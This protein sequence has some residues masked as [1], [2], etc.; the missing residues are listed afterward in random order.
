MRSAHVCGSGWWQRT[1]AV[2][3]VVA[4]A[5]GVLAPSAQASPTA[6]ATACPE[7][8]PASTFGDVYSGDVH[9]RAVRCLVA[10]GVA[11]GAAL[12]SYAPSSAVTRGQMATFLAR[13][14]RVAGQPLDTPVQGQFDDVSGTHRDNIEALADLGIVSGVDASTF[15]PSR[16]VT[17]AQMATFID[18]VL[19]RFGSDLA[20]GTAQFE[21]VNPSSVHASAIRKLAAADIAQGRSSSRFDPNGA[22]TRAQMA[23]F[24]MRGG[25][26]LAD[27]GVLEPPYRE[28]PL[29]AALPDPLAEVRLDEPF[30]PQN[31]IVAEEP[32]RYVT[33]VGPELDRF[34]HRVYYTVARFAD[35]A[36]AATAAANV[37]DWYRSVLPS[38]LVTEY[39]TP[40]RTSLG[41]GDA[42]EWF[43]FVVG[44]AG[45]VVV[46]ASFGVAGETEEA[47]EGSDAWP[48]EDDLAYAVDY[49][50]A[51]LAPDDPVRASSLETICGRVT[52][53]PWYVVRTDAGVSCDEAMRVA[54]RYW[55]TPPTERA[56]WTGDGFFCGLAA[57]RALGGC[58]RLDDRDV[59][60]RMRA[61]RE[62]R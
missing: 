10:Y 5:S 1:K 61:Q 17:R 19:T 51:W 28:D 25:D 16:A 29:R 15:E 36:A 41:Y 2:V 39:T 7:P 9:A 35:A 26:L 31:R 44:H 24:L 62:L 50:L 58:E 14:L 20:P 34:G 4:L 60:F 40:T 11:Q 12:G 33:A 3:M 6:L 55:R 38:G 47:F 45:D 59:G 27:D 13:L 18:R 8:L 49:A 21:D 53:T 52:S 37:V 56:G 43:R 22:V 30:V 46:R 23:S 48:Y 32:V 57:T 42:L 54:G